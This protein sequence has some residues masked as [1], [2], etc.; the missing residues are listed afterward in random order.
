MSTNVK[1]CKDDNKL[2]SQKAVF[3]NKWKAK[4]YTVRQ[5]V[6]NWKAGI[7]NVKGQLEGTD[8]N[9]KTIKTENYELECDVSTIKAKL[10]FEDKSKWMN[11]DVK[12]DDAKNYIIEKVKKEI[13][14]DVTKM[15]DAIRDKFKIIV[16]MD[17]D[18]II[19]RLDDV[20]G[21]VY[22]LKKDVTNMKQISKNE[23]LESRVNSLRT[24]VKT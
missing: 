19:E 17:T 21:L 22:S 13:L 6:N 1:L 12:L 20:V 3:E 15:G 18:E 7:N 14:E 23:N 4:I 2:M 5:G 8:K 9:L 16:E 11:S 24:D 10:N